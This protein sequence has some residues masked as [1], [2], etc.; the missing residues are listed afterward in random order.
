MHTGTTILKAAFHAVFG[1]DMQF[2][3]RLRAVPPNW[4]VDPDQ[5]TGAAFT[6][7]KVTPIRGS[8]KGG[9]ARLTCNTTCRSG[10]V[11]D[12]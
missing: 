7:E 9:N 2:A 6:P 1:S 3:F 12:K 10:N 4:V 8:T 11:W 5:E